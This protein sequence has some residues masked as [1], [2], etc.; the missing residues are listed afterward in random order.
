M[1]KSTIATNGVRRTMGKLTDGSCS[2]S[3]TAQTLSH[4]N[5]MILDSLVNGSFSSINYYTFKLTKSQL[6]SF[7]S[8]NQATL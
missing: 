7:K 4:Y 2:I 8:I 5:F 6:H 3:Q 1:D